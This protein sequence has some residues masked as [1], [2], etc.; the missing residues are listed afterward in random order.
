M[1]KVRLLLCTD[2]DRTVIPNGFQPEA[3]NA[4]REFNRFCHRSDVRLVYV[5]GRHITLVRQAIKNYALPEPDFAITD[6]GTRIY[7]TANKRWQQM[8][9]WEAKIDRDW[10]DRTHA[11]LKGML[12][13]IRELRL[14]ESSKQNT[15]K[16]S[17]Y[18]PLYC[19]KDQVI[20]RIEALM[21][22]A[23]ID[24][25]ILWSIDEPNNIGLLDVLPKHATKLH[26]IEFLQ[27]KLG[28]TQREVVFAGDSGNDLPVLSSHI[29]S[30]LVAN[31]SEEIKKA[32]LQ[33]SRHNGH[34]SSLYLATNDESGHNGNYAAGV[35]QGVFHYSPYFAQTS[36]RETLS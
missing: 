28:Y 9:D 25:S 1:K 12:T 8:A 29:Q 10:H 14:Q 11:D 19:N 23:G 7:Q 15:H 6:V 27:D 2:M 18:L 33:L 21:S 17:Y 5:T 35:L 22:D 16:L 24:V 30:V 20:A 32:A 36:D 4:R 34:A 26:A 13:R 31:A 3:A